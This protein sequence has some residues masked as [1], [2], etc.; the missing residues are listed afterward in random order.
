VNLFEQ[1]DYKNYLRL[2]IREQ[3]KSRG[4]KSR[5][6]E[7]LGQ[8]PSFLSQVLHT[9]VELTQDH[10]FRLARFWGLSSLEQDY[11]M[12]LV[13][14]ARA[15]G[16]DY[17][18]FLKERLERLRSENLNLSQRFKEPTVEE[19]RRS[20][21]YYGA[22][23][24]GALHMLLTIPELNSPERL[25]ARVGLPVDFVVQGLRELAEMGLA[26]E[27]NGKWKTAINSIHLKKGS[28]LSAFNHQIWR[29]RAIEQLMMAP[30]SRE[31]SLNYT[32]LYTLSHEDFG[33]LRQLILKFVEDTRDLVTPSKEETLGCLN[34]DW[35][36]V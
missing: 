3:G 9:H 10:A 22:W 31:E 33:R 5:V 23:Y 21:R 8:A 30:K 20:D 14:F 13:S 6:S 17:K 24:R 18:K 34:L 28:S 32:A 29:N 16:P 4:Y 36:E 19:D 35:F 15:S 26:T 25:S 1:S 12:T 7:A 11:W 2:R 27:E